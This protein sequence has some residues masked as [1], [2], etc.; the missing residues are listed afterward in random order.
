MAVA[1][2]HLPFG[3]R[4]SGSRQPAT[5]GTGASSGGGAPASSRAGAAASL[6]SSSIFRPEVSAASSSGDAGEGVSGSRSPK[7]PRGPGAGSS[8]RGGSTLT[9]GMDESGGAT[10]RGLSGMSNKPLQPAS[11]THAGNAH[12][13]NTVQTDASAPSV[14]E[15]R[16]AAAHLEETRNN[17]IGATRTRS[18]LTLSWLARSLQRR[19]TRGG[20][21]ARAGRRGGGRMAGRHSTACPGERRPRP[22]L[23]RRHESREGCAG[24]RHFQRVMRPSCAAIHPLTHPIEQYQS[25]PTQPL[26]G[27]AHGACFDDTM[28]GAR[29]AA[30][31]TPRS[32][33][34]HPLSARARAARAPAATSARARGCRR[35]G[36]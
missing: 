35:R 29:R 23:D 8:A 33:A 26:G 4:L 1:T 17:L 14:R 28:R 30:P 5:G 12:A 16:N 24:S 2:K 9:P 20:I 19:V 3:P 6:R 31:I 32:R 15:G 34:R 10:K 22:E 7:T 18:E 25:G 21:S 36:A 27:Y 13:G 11:N